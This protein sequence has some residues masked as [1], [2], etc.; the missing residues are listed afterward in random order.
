MVICAPKSFGGI[1]WEASQHKHLKVKVQECAQFWPQTDPPQKHFAGAFYWQ[2]QGMTWVPKSPRDPMGSTRI[3]WSSQKGG[4]QGYV[5]IFFGLPFENLFPNDAKNI[6]FQS[7]LT[8]KTTDPQTRVSI[9]GVATPYPVYFLP[10]LASLS[11]V[12]EDSDSSVTRALKQTMAMSLGSGKHSEEEL[13]LHRLD[14]LH[15]KQRE[16]ANETHEYQD[17]WYHLGRSQVGF[18]ALKNKYGYLAY[19]KLMRYGPAALFS[20]FDNLLENPLSHYG[21]LLEENIYLPS[22]HK[23]HMTLPWGSHTYDFDGNDHAL[24]LEITIVSSDFEFESLDIQ[25]TY[26]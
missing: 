21:T 2:A 5:R 24:S 4:E 23:D 13:V 1:K 9:A 8:L 22:P 16:F 3:H 26:E 18:M 17:F 25:G 20:Y 6:G 10:E 7:Y 11:M 15:H 14:F 19:K 12:K